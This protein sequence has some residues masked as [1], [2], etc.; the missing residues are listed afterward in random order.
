MFKRILFAHNATPSAERALLYLEHLAKQEEAEVLVLHVYQPPERYIAN[1]GYTALLEQFE[2]VAHEVV[3]DTVMHLRD[4]GI[5]ALAMVDTGTPAHVILR[6][7][8]EENVS[9]IVLGTRGPSSMADILVGD[10]TTEVL[11]HAHCP[12]FLVP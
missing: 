5:T 3:N 12:V 1:Q 8:Q 7:A 4:A 11:R 2:S 9:L 6:T 10:V